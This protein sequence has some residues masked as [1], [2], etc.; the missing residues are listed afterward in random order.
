MHFFVT[1]VNKCPTSFIDLSFLSP[2]HDNDI[3]A[4]V[5]SP[6]RVIA[7][8]CPLPEVLFPQVGACSVPHLLWA[9]SLKSPSQTYSIFSLLYFSPSLLWLFEFGY[10]CLVYWMVYL[11]HYN[12]WSP[13]K[14]KYSFVRVLF[15]LGSWTPRTFLHI[16][17]T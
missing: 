4:Q 15:T 7:L 1:R 10:A 2:P 11:P 6:F 3:F 13:M 8:L 17:S 5:C 14:R 16:I 12:S 9:F